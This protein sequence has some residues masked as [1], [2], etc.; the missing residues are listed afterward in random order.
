MVSIHIQI[1]DDQYTVD[2]TEIQGLGFYFIQ[3]LY[4]NHISLTVNGRR[5]NWELSCT[6]MKFYEYDNSNQYIVVK[7][8]QNLLKYVFEDSNFISGV[9][10]AI[11][12]FEL[13]FDD[14]V[15]M[16]HL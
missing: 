16:I 10:A 5:P 1:G 12:M 8:D 15:Y 3:Q 13:K 7:Q 6:T 4:C 11:K 2:L 9:K 14:I